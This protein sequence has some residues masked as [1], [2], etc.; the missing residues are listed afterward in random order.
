M[1]WNELAFITVIPAG[2]DT[3][4][5]LDAFRKALPSIR[6]SDDGKVMDLMF[7]VLTNAC[8]SIVVSKESV[9]NNSDVNA[10]AA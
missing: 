6:F 8:V 4:V 3:F 5:K 7:G 9:A 2:I 1:F 10:D